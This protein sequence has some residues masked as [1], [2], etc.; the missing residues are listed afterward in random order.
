MYFTYCFSSCRVF[1][2]SKF[3]LYLTYNVVATT[4]FADLY[5][6]SRRTVMGI[7]V[8]TFLCYPF[9][10]NVIF[11]LCIVT[12]TV[13]SLSSIN[14]SINQMYDEIRMQKLKIYREV[15]IEYSTTE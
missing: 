10:L 1:T 5:Y 2:Q 8:F 4:I 14:Q 11:L 3:G 15:L 12:L 9:I 7:S 13:N 6:F